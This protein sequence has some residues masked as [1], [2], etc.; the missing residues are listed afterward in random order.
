MTAPAPAPFPDPRER[1]EFDAAE[2]I[3]THPPEWLHPNKS[4]V[5]DV[6]TS[7]GDAFAGTIRC[8]RWGEMALP[9]ALS[10]DASELTFDIRPGIYDYAPDPNGRTDWHV[11]FADPHLFGMYGWALFAQDEIQ[12]AEHPILG[13][14]REA[15]IEPGGGLDPKTIDPARRPTPVT[16]TGVQRRVAI[17]TRD[18]YGNAF[19][20]AS[21]ARVRTACRGISPPTVS[22]ILA[23]AAP[24]PGQGVYS[25]DEILY[26]VH[27]AYTGFR[28]AR[29]ESEALV[30]D[31]QSGEGAGSAPP[32]GVLVHTGFWGCGAFGGNRTLMPMLQAL[33]ADLAAVDIAFHAVDDAGAATAE[34][35]I[36]E[37]RRLR[38]DA[39]RGETAAVVDAMVGL[40]FEWGVSDGN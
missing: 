27:C 35:A 26:V 4:V 16:V 31:P 15:L 28:A 29:V 2:L 33:A 37:Y 21:E 22:N 5:Y 8:A 36:A 30:A 12:V 18:V 13:S 20:A 3:R 23:M 25:R 17:D 6:A 9:A 14:L 7:T 34:Q 10:P 19:A 39:P 32:R 1:A 40:G 11:N 38:A 24:T